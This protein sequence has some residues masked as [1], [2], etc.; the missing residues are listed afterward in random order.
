MRGRPLPAIC[1]SIAVWGGDSLVVVQGHQ[2]MLKPALPLVFHAHIVDGGDGR[3]TQR[4]LP[5][6]VGWN[7]A[8][9]SSSPCLYALQAG[10]LRLLEVSRSDARQ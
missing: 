3:A 4:S 1:A 6:M 10:S 7:S 2:F 8:C 9:G 5:G